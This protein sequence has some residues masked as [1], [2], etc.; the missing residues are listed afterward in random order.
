MLTRWALPLGV[1]VFFAATAAGYGVFRDE[2]YYFACARTPA[3]G[4]AARRLRARPRRRF[5]DR[6]PPALGGRGGMPFEDNLTIWVARDPR[7]ALADIW[8]ATKHFD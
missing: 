8:P 3:R 5:V 1:L 4:G 6:R 7:V 2:L